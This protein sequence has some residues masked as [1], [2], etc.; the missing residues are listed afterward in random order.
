MKK[1]F[2]L[3]VFVFL[4]SLGG[5]AL[6]EQRA[7]ALVDPVTMYSKMDENSKSWEVSLPDEGVVV[8]S[9]SRDKQN[10]LWYKVTVNG[11]TGWLFNEGIRLRMGPKSKFASNAYKRCADLRAKV[12]KGK[13]KS[14]SKGEPID[15]IVTYVGK[16]VLFQ[17]QS[18][19]DLYFKVTGSKAS[20]DILGF[21]AIGMS[22]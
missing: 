5:T 18:G 2:A 21:D 12:V 9:A 17:T 8:P 15:N 19:R 6:A 20:R 16:G 1:L 7:F 14:W 11:K 22:W 10:R 13:D 3:F 4:L